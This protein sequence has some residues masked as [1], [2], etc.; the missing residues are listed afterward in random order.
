MKSFVGIWDGKKLDTVETM[1]PFETVK[2]CLGGAYL[3]QLP[4]SYSKVSPFF[5]KL[6][7][8][9][10]AVLCDEDGTNKGLPVSFTSAEFSLVGNIGFVNNGGEDFQPLTEKQIILL[11]KLFNDYID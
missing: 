7:E 4:T 1:E 3:Q 10:I 9:G 5:W 8:A 2:E 11:H 6:A